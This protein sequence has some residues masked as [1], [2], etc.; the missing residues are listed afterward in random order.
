MPVADRRRQIAAEAAALVSRYGS[1]GV[2]MQT[3]AD[4]VGLTLP[5]LH[6]HVAGRDELLT[7]IIETYYDE[8]LDAA[9]L[10]DRLRALATAEDGTLR[11]P[12]ALRRIVQ[13][14]ADRPELV[15]LFVR[16]AVEAHDPEHPAHDYYRRR[17]HDLLTALGDLPWHL[18][19]RFRDPAAATDL[20]R[21][22]LAAMDGCE[23]QSLTDPAESLT[24]LWARA[25]RTLFGAPEW[26][27]HR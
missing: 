6:H 15:A 3:V 10:P 27:D 1:Y 20:L 2:S 24:D 18:P 25:E 19:A 13:A 12:Q 22:A 11:L 7:L 17:H 5:G 8:H 23:V 16:L 26:D 4:A 9:H 14:N 21:T